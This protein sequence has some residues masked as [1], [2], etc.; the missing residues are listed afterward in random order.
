MPNVITSRVSR[1]L[2][3]TANPMNPS[4][5]VV[6]HSVTVREWKRSGLV[7]TPRWRLRAAL[8]NATIDSGE[9]WTYRVVYLIEEHDPSV[10]TPSL[11]WIIRYKYNNHDEALAQLERLAEL[12]P[13]L[14]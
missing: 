6:T 10:L 12:E 8:L 3:A 13:G 11:A 7:E 1:V 9:P 14:T 2:E 5:L 4:G